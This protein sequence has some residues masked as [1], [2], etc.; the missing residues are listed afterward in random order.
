MLYEAKR[1]VFKTGVRIPPPPP[2]SIRLVFCGGGVPE[3]DWAKSN[4][5]D[6]TVGDD[7]KSSKIYKCK[8]SI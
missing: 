2:E 8:H 5:V 4:G 1:K 3:F 6:S 7:C